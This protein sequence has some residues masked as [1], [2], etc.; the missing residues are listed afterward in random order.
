MTTMHIYF[1]C[2]SVDNGIGEKGASVLAEALK[3]NT[4]LPN[5]YLEGNY[6]HYILHSSVHSYAFNFHM[7]LYRLHVCN[8]THY[9]SH[10]SILAVNYVYTFIYSS[11][12]DLLDG[13]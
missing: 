8:E 7:F 4:N 10:S 3:M 5:L 13:T 9:N 1:T 2:S 12:R 11:E 6:A